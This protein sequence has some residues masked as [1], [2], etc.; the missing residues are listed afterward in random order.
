MRIQIASDLHL[1]FIA[2][3]IPY[4]SI[5]RPAPGAEL[6]VLAGDIGPVSYVVELFKDWPV[7][8]LYVLGNHEFYG[9]VL[10][11]VYAQA[12]ELC[13]GTNVHLLQNSTFIHGDVRFLGC[14]LWTD[15]LLNGHEHRPAVMALA[16]RGM[17]DHH[18]ITLPSGAH[19]T[20]EDALHENHRSQAWLREQLAQPWQGKT[21]LV[22]HHGLHTNSIDE[23]YQGSML[24]GAFVSELS[25]LLENVD[26]LVHGHVHSSHQY[27]A[28]KCRVYTNPCGYA[29]NHQYCR[30]AGELQFENHAFLRNMAIDI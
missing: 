3:S 6:L 15:Y 12:M 23:K 16:R 30:S 20:P 22:T 5:V 24:N 18:A 14:T 25:S 4:H 27:L 2:Q 7:P 29:R 10:P 26:V 21:V 11:R 28:G 13:E 9:G 1:E 8:V 17:A 19:F